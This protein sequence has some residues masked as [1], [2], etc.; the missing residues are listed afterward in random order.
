MVEKVVYPTCGFF[1]K[2]FTLKEIKPSIET[3]YDR[4]DQLVRLVRGHL[5]NKCS[6]F[7]TKVMKRRKFKIA[8]ETP[9]GHQRLFL[10]LSK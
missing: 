10:L 2:T 9:P 1:E 4:K 8:T 3:N 7:E 5:L 6:I